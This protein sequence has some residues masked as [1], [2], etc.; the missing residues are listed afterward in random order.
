MKIT[1]TNASVTFTVKVAPRASKNEIAGV[2][3]DTVKVRLYAPPVDG[4]ANVALVKFL[5]ET[6]GVSR[7]QVEIVSGETGRRK[8]VRVRGITAEQMKRFLNQAAG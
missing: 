4:K 3:G 6:L 8:L 2:E 7:A 1:E 5:A